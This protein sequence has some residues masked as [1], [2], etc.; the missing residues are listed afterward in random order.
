MPSL[1][2]Q[3]SNLPSVNRRREIAASRSALLAMTG[4][5]LTRLG[6]VELAQQ[7]LH[8]AELFGVGA[9]ERGNVAAAPVVKAAPALHAE[10]PIGMELLH[11]GAGLGAVMEVRQHRAL[12]ERVR[13]EPAPILL[14][15][16]AGDAHARA[17]E[18]LH[19]EIDGCRV[20][21]ALLDEMISLVR[22][23]VLQPVDEES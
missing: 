22:K 3:R 21:Q 7:R 11:H 8:A 18:P 5:F 17:E 6:L 15:H 1:R 2:A 20:D 23:G 19:D 10:M 16:D 4:K 12:R 9:P 14:L 13:V